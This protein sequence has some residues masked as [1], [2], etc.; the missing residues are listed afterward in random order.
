M[1]VM[2]APPAT[3]LCRTKEQVECPPGT[4][5]SFRSLPEAVLLTVTNL[6]YSQRD[7]R[8]Q[9]LHHERNQVLSGRLL[10]AELSCQRAARQSGQHPRRVAS[11]QVSPAAL[12]NRN[13]TPLSS[14][15]F[16]RRSSSC[17]RRVGT[18]L[19]VARA[20]R[21]GL[22]RTCRARGASAC[23]SKPRSG[24]VRCRRSVV[25]RCLFRLFCFIC[26]EILAMHDDDRLGVLV[27]EVARVVADGT[28]WFVVCVS[29]IRC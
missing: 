20:L 10:A 29:L 9:R 26:D 7:D 3:P 19:A 15:L 28:A 23:R 14:S 22:R 8:R 11:I 12:F 16:C 24:P 2:T 25:R 27:E 17:R 6:A 5:G 21:S 18:N 13:Q 4:Y 1:V